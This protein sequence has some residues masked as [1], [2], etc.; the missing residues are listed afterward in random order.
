MAQTNFKKA[1]NVEALRDKGVAVQA[2]T[3]VYGQ[4]IMY[5]IPK[6]F[7]PARQNVIGPSY[8]QELLPKG[9][10]LTAWTE[11]I[12]LSGAAGAAQR[13]NASAE[14]LVTLL[15]GGFQGACPD[16]FAGEGLTEF[17]INGHDVYVAVT[18]CGT[19]GTAP[20]AFSEMALIV[21]I[22]GKTDMYT[23]QWAERGKPSAKPIAIQ[24]DKWAERFKKLMPVKLCPIV[25][26]EK[27]PYP[28]CIAQ[29]VE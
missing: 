25:P 18:G 1:D 2:V 7:S 21:A 17:K 23:L 6:G 15:A 13:P 10:K 28:S 19:L 22:K 27:A 16:S 24:K 29:K 4:L 26:N 8:I 11:M 20:N 12:T 14:G 5:T 9:Q 3:P